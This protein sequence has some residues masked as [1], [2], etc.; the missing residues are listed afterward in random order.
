MNNLAYDNIDDKKQ[1]Y[2]TIK[3]HMDERLRKE[4]LIWCCKQV[5]TELCNT[6]RPGINSTYHEKEV[7]WQI[8]SLAFMHGLDLDLVAQKIE[9]VA[10]KQKL[11]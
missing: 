11:D 1:I 3:N 5:S 10:R 2:F 9:K 7:F 4:F 8:M 6:L